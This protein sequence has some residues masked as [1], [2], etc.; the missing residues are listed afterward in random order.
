MDRLLP[1]IS[2]DDL[3]LATD[4]LIRPK[5]MHA[6]LSSVSAT[7]HVHINLVR[8]ERQPERFRAVSAK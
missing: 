5:N 1:K 3:G 4:R 7:P 8:L 2:S 6:G